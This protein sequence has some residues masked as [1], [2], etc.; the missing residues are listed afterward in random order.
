[1]GEAIVA[2]DLDGRVTYLNDAAGA[3]HGW[4]NDAAL[5]A[6]WA[7]VAHGDLAPAQAEDIAEVLDAGRVWSGELALR[8]FDGSMVPVWSTITPVLERARCIGFIGVSFDISDRKAAEA[9]AQHVATHD[10]LTDLANHRSLTTQLDARLAALQDG[11]RASVILLDVGGL[12]P[13][14]D[15]FGHATR[16]WVVRRCAGHLGAL[17]H[18]QDL[19]AR[20]SDRTFALCCCHDLTEKDA[21][22]YG[23]ALRRELATPGAT[24]RQDIHLDVAAAVASA[25]PPDGRAEVV[26]RNATTALDRAR[27]SG[28]TQVYDS[29]MRAALARSHEVEALVDRVIARGAVT[30]GYQP[31]V[32][33][34]D[35]R[36]VGAEALLRLVDDHG[37]P[38]PAI[39]AVQAAERNGRIGELGALVLRQACSDA[40]T[41]Q[42]ASPDHP[43][44]V[45]ANI[46]AQQLDEPDLPLQVGGALALAALAPS[47]L[48]L[49]ITET[50]I[51][52]DPVRSIAV[53]SRLRAT[54]VHLSADDFGTGYSSLAYLKR[55]PIDVVKVD[56]TFVAGL[57]TSTEDRAI[58][59][60][61]VGIADAL[62]LTVVAEG[63]ERE[64][65]R[66]DLL[67]LG[68]DHGQGFLW[69]RAVP[70]SD[71][72][73]R[74]Q[75]EQRDTSP[76]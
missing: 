71:V 67:A 72:L 73:A 64:V 18:D 25:G 8:R 41:W 53:L 23:E 66:D 45:T 4:R 16:E 2:W 9:L 57:P 52:R 1:M 29:S 75:Q 42:A 17:I 13:V 40:A 65:Q 44:L 51:M 7:D 63:V 12:G 19:L 30:L 76:R 55:L 38:V 3:L 24:G 33:L 5:G 14:N 11:R 28:S 60:A 70:A 49:E 36:T 61:V 10:P 27:S 46:S 22:E 56:Q 35:E 37:Q 59:R 31:I 68:V 6:R 21:L 58:V 43:V 47:S 20:Y 48:W 62:G 69:S 74:L 26:L 54:G 34:H 50:A 39:E 32:S 15:T